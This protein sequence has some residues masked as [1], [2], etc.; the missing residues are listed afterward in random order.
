MLMFKHRSSSKSSIMMVEEEEKKQQ[1]KIAEYPVEGREF[2]GQGTSLGSNAE[3]VIV[4]RVILTGYPYKL[5]KKKAVI[6]YM[7][8]NPEDVK[9]FKPVELFTKHRLKGHIRKSLGTHGLMKCIFNDFVRSDDIIC[10]PLYRRVFPKWF[11][12]T[13]EGG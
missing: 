11:P 10:L 5:T 3:Q 4:K 12:L 2:I 6:R 8:F 7:F 13:W 1:H 9:Y